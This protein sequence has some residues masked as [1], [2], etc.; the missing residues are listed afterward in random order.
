MI[1]FENKIRLASRDIERLTVLT[2]T[3][4]EGVLSVDDL[5]A[6]LDDQIALIRGNSKWA[7]MLRVLIEHERVKR[8]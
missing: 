6:F 4:P 8:P 5:D 7:Q 3:K 1:C 2:G